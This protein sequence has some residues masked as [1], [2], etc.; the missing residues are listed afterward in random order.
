MMG[1]IGWWKQADPLRRT[2]LSFWAVLWSAIAAGLVHL[3]VPF[4]HPWGSLIAA[5]A[6]IA[7]QLSTPWINPNE[8]LHRV[9]PVTE[10]A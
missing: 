2:R 8:R 7:V 5:G 6:S 1:L 4:P 10:V 9:S 3:F